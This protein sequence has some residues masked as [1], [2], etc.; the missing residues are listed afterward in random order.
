MSQQWGHGIFN[1][2]ENFWSCW[3]GFNYPQ[4]LI[5]A[6]RTRFDGSDPFFNQCNATPCI[7]RPSLES[8]LPWL[9]EQQARNI[10]REG[11]G[12]EGDCC[13]DIFCGACCT[14]CV[15]CQLNDE[16]KKR[17]NVNITSRAG[18]EKWSNGLCDCCAA[19]CGV[20]LSPD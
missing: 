20:C 8:S 6:S 18:T 13:S 15:A 10:I 2:C 16:T 5:A 9:I 11:Y 1:F 14:Q 12:I 19:G 3:Y 17:G 4:C 7:V